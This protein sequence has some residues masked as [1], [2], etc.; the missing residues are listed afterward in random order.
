M[1]DG[2]D[3]TTANQQTTVSKKENIVSLEVS[4]EEPCPP[5]DDIEKDI[6]T[7]ISS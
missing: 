4:S 7:R 6:T 1:I 3:H 5:L 2:D